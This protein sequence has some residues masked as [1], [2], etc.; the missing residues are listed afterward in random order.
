MAG[1]QPLVFPDSLS[2]RPDGSLAEWTSSHRR[3]RVHVRST[4]AAVHPFIQS[5]SRGHP[6]LIAVGDLAAGLCRARVEAADLDL[7]DCGTHQ[8]FLASR[9]QREL[10]S[11]GFLH[12]AT[13]DA[14]V[15]LFGG[16]FIVGAA[17]GLLSD[18]FGIAVV[19]GNTSRT[20]VAQ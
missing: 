4:P 19:G 12:P 18:A 16:L 6:G 15:A 8:L 2:H 11:R 17:V 20:P 14:R 9:A 5:V 1:G 7:L 13:R 3:D 10:G